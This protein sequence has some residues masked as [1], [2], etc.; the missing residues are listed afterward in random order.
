MSDSAS[1]P[2]S[3]PRSSAFYIINPIFL[4]V[5]GYNV[6]ELL[7]WIFNT[8]DRRRGL[9][10]GSILISTL[11]LAAFIIA[12]SLRTFRTDVSE[13]LTA[14]YIFAFSYT[15]LLTAHIL[16]LY[17]R[18]HLVLHSYRILRGILIMI[19]VTSVLSVPAQLTVSLTLVSTRH[20]RLARAEYILERVVFL[21]A[22]VREFIVCAIY[23]VQAYRNLHPIAQA[24]GRAGKR[25]LVYLMAVQVAAI[26]LDT[27]FLVQI[28]M[29]LA[30]AANGYC[31]LLY[32]IKL[33]MEFG[34]LNSLV[35]LLRSPLVLGSRSDGEGG[36]I[37]E[38]GDS[39]RTN[40]T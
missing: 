25:V 2:S 7:L 1:L 3:L 17:S 32:S 16:V 21:G 8:F 22:T 30:L 27:G 5:A 40:R 9:Y 36:L 12:Q 26:V 29:D 34:V 35:T 13:L 4:S 6:L 11:S 15:A 33:K 38:L 39:G 24:K 18:L 20:P 28:Y 31:A 19:I 10:F 37:P 14:G 23:T